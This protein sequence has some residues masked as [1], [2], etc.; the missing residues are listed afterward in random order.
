[1]SDE[2]R[3]IVEIISKEVAMVNTKI[4]LYHPY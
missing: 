1:M 2:M 3:V 4:S